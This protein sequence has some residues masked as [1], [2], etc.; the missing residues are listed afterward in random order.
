MGNISTGRIHETAIWV[1]FE[2]GHSTHQ[3]WDATMV[4]DTVASRATAT[5]FV[6]LPDKKTAK[7]KLKNSLPITVFNK[8]RKGRACKLN[9]E[10]QNGKWTVMSSVHSDK[11][12]E[13]MFRDSIPDNTTYVLAW[14]MKAHDSKVLRKILPEAQMS[15]LTLLDPLMWFRKHFTLPSNSLAKSGAGT[16]RNVMKAGNY[17]YLGKAH[18]S[19]VDTLHMRDVTLNAAATLSKATEDPTFTTVK[20]VFID[21]QILLKKPDK[22][23]CTNATIDPD[24]DWMWDAK[25]WD[26]SKKLRP[27]MSKQF[28]RKFI[29]TLKKRG[30][31]P[32]K[33]N[34]NGINASKKQGTFQKYLNCSFTQHE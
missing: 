8:L 3:L 1:D 6:T 22:Q 32:S 5:R 11:S 20:C 34:I 24:T 14:N 29:Q 15:C 27:E 13:N 12:V 16:P 17:E 28:K 19:F 18:T 30:L 26:N 31:S 23:K 33:E 10:R 9:Y 25:Y 4:V 2:G 7:S 21:D